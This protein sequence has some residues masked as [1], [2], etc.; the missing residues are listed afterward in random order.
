V[1]FVIV[2]PLFAAYIIYFMKSKERAVARGLEKLYPELGDLVEPDDQFSPFDFECRKY[3]IEVK[4]RS[5][6]WDPWFIE[7]VKYNT[8]I[9]IA[10]SLKKDFIF[11]TEVKNVAYL[12]NISRMTRNDYDFKWSNKLLP[13]STEFNKTAM[14]EK[15][16]GY[17]P[18]SDAQILI[19]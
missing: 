18:I 4:C 12:Y 17:L 8:N 14:I 7:E 11:L 15:P 1:G 9:N 19:L 10:E 6:V 2:I 16:V 13:N 5:K 3:I